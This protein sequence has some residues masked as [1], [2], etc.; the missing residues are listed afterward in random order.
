MKSP[1]LCILITLCITLSNTCMEPTRLQSLPEDILLYIIALTGNITSWVYVN[2]QFSSLITKKNMLTLYPW[3]LSKRDHICFMVKSAKTENKDLIKLGLKTALQCGHHY[4]TIL[5]Y[6]ISKEDSI[7]KVIKDFKKNTNTE[8]PELL[9]STIIAI[10][11]G[12]FCYINEYKKHIVL[13]KNDED[14]KRLTPLLIAAELNHLNLVE[15]FLA[16]DPTSLNQTPTCSTEPL[17]KN[18]TQLFMATPLHI[19][20]RQQYDKM[21]A[22]LLSFKNIDLTAKINDLSLVEW[23][24]EKSNIN[25]LKLV[26]EQLK[27]KYPDQYIS[28]LSAKALDLAIN[29][30]SKTSFLLQEI[31]Y[32]LP[33]K[34]QPLHIAA[35][36]NST[37]LIDTL[38][39]HPHTN[40]NA[41][42]EKGNTALFLAIKK[43][44]MPFVNALLEKITSHTMLNDDKQNIFHAAAY[45]DSPLINTLIAQFIPKGTVHYL[46]DKDINGH[47]PLALAQELEHTIT[48]QSITNYLL[49]TSTF[50]KQQ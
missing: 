49:F 2:T 26:L 28:F 14:K 39:T 32:K 7:N 13:K 6:F 42:D 46:N 4:L 3:C 38:C 30:K 36:H 37:Y 50:P 16:Q 10:Y 29:N 11:R 18:Q 17:N 23:T 8:C 44:N 9:L 25:I 40:I 33:E 41:Q 5:S 31:E 34:E 20:I 48:A 12:D 21:C 1:L 19:A 15:F 27:I 24:C 35:R 22:L 45:I 47:T 43:N